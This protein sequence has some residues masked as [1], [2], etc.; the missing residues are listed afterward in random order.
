M[1]IFVRCVILGKI[2]SIRRQ[3]VHIWPS[4]SDSIT[5]SPGLAA[6][7]ELNYSKGGQRTFRADPLDI[8]RK[9]NRHS[10]DIQIPL[11]EGKKI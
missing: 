6:R 3:L 4:I 2:A 9:F 1:N 11:S 8:E 7:G 5:A 10:K